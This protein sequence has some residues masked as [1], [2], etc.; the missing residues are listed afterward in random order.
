MPPP[1]NPLQPRRYVSPARAQQA[2]GTRR[3][4]LEA[5]R[6]LFTAHGYA[7]V[8]MTQLAA[9]AGVAVDTVYASVGRK[10]AV[11]RALIES[12]LSGT[13][14]AVPAEQREEVRR[15]RAA[16][17]ARDKIAL[18]ATAVTTVGE[19]MAPI[20]LALREAAAS[21]P[22]CA[23]L[24]REITERRAANMRLFTAD[25]RATGELRSDLDDDDVADIVW[26][27]GSAE[28]WAL[29]VGARNWSPDRFRTWLQDA[30][31]RTLLA[32][33]Q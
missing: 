1:V 9:A 19:R 13:D 3:R 29:L 26:S 27:M 20:S 31:C 11:L 10:P 12:A 30:W 7:A 28:Y 21:D 15:V 33:H 2:A 23:A 18:Y 6:T 32:P 25:L 24:H 22:E 5:A 8:S 16:P 17:S 14:E 4:V